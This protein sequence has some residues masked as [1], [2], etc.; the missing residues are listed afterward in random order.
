MKHDLMRGLKD[1][2]VYA[3]GTDTEPTELA[4]I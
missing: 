3:D 4:A 2:Y 1:Q